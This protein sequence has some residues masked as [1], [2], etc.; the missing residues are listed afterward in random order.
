MKNHF[1]S[2]FN[3]TNR[4]RTMIFF[5]LSVI[6]F[7]TSSFVGIS[8][9]PPGITLFYSGITFLFLSLFH[10]W[11]RPRNYAILASICVLL[12]IITFLTLY[13]VSTFTIKPGVEHNPTDTENFIDA[14][15]VI[16]ILFICI[17]GVII[18]FLG[19]A[20][21]AIKNRWIK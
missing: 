17:P 19:T 14:T 2:L 5:L 7:I 12:I 16:F 13:I 8:D 21:W 4:L 15:I 18:G 6:F 1:N 3:K 11:R 10:P 20:Y 9:N